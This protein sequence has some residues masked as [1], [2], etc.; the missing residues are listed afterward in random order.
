MAEVYSLVFRINFR[1]NRERSAPPDFRK[2]IKHIFKT[3]SDY[4]ERC[5]H[6]G[7]RFEWI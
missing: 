5:L 1:F 6:I 7:W 2:N 3:T 4:L